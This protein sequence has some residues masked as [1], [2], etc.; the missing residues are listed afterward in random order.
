MAVEK[1]IGED[2][3]DQSRGDTFCLLEVEGNGSGLCRMADCY[4]FQ[5]RHP[6]CVSIDM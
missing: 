1:E 4:T 2:L 6:L 5:K 3:N